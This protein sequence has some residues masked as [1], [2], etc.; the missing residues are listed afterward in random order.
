MNIFRTARALLLSNYLKIN[1]K[2]LAER[3]DFER[4]TIRSDGTTI[5]TENNGVSEILPR[6]ARPFLKK[7]CRKMNGGDLTENGDFESTKIRSHGSCFIITKIY[8]ALDFS[9]LSVPFS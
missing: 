2:D 7:Y 5:R 3:G 6:C 9:A 8:G 4:W 1:G